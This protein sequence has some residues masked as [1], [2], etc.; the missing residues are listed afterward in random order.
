MIYP[1]GIG[2]SRSRRNWYV[3]AQRRREPANRQLTIPMPKRG[4]QSNYGSRT[5]METEAFTAATAAAAKRN[6]RESEKARGCRP[7]ERVRSHRTDRDGN[8][9]N[10]LLEKRRIQQVIHWKWKIE[11]R[12]KR[13]DKYVTA[14][15]KLLMSMYLH[16][17]QLQL[18]QRDWRH[19]LNS[20]VTE[21]KKLFTMLEPAAYNCLPLWSFDCMVNAKVCYAAHAELVRSDRWSFLLCCPQFEFKQPHNPAGRIFWIILSAEDE[22]HQNEN[23][24]WRM[25]KA[26]CM[27]LPNNSQHEEP[28]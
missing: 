18:E 11:A 1:K 7:V 19:K 15:E 17:V 12:V 22:D 2:R 26:A 20:P 9:C 13:I 6:A 10:N 23:E 28:K 24:R 5:G 14:E 4:V 16:A 8:I 3:F 27:Q 21:K 25:A